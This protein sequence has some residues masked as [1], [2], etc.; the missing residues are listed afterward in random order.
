[1]TQIMDEYHVPVLLKAS[2]DGLNVKED[3]VYVDVTFGGGGHSREILNR[4][5]D[6]KLF[7]FDQD[8]DALTNVPEDECFE[9][10]DQNFRFLKNN[11]RARG[12]REVDGILAD[13]GVSSHQFNVPE[14]GFTF[15]QNASLDM[16]MDRENPVT[17]AQVLQEWEEA[18]LANMFFQYGELRNSR[19]VARAIL[20]RRSE[21]EMETVNDLIA[22]V[23][24]LAPKR[25]EHQFYAKVFQAVRVEVNDELGALEE[26]LEQS[27]ALL[28]EGGKL[29]VISYHSLEDR[30]VK[31]FF[32]FG[33]A[34]GE[35]K[36]DFYGNLIRPLKAV[37]KKPIVPDDDEIEINNRARSAR[38]RIAEKL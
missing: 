18:D 38:L 24:H 17:A 1:M 31:H 27:I 37:N 2:V 29:V 35:P 4:L 32:K 30:M 13:L 34:R 23:E 36:K 20:K 8:A 21:S 33:N 12:V 9:L 15:R 28:K 14:R 3:G 25:K 22:A 19:A 5:D 11:L 6:G 26:M 7:A 16:R 10:I